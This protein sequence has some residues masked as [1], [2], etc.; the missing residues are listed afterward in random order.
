M[1]TATTQK[2]DGTGSEIRLPVVDVDVHPTVDHTDAAFQAHLS[3]RWRRYLERFGTGNIATES[4]IPPQRAMTH[5]LDAVD[6]SGRVASDPVFTRKQL[7]DEFDMSGALLSDAM[8][9]VYSRGGQNY[10]EALA[11]EL[12]SAYNDVHREVWFESDPRYYASINL[13]F[14]H[15]EKAAAEIARCREGE[16]GDR[17]AAALV[18]SRAE[19]PIGNPRYWPIFEACEHYGIPL[20]MHTSM[21]RRMTGCGPINFYFEWHTGF[22]QRNP[23]IVS[24]MVF[25]G[26]FDRFPGLNVVL[27]EQSWAWAVPYA[28]RL[29]STWQMLRDEV[30]DLER[31][32]S[33]YFAD[34]WYFA[35]QPMPEPEN[36]E[37]IDQVLDQF[38]GFFGP[39]HLLFASDYPHW[40]FDSPYDAM[41]MTLS[42]EQRGRILGG[43]ASKVLGI[44][45]LPNSGVRLQ[46]EAAAA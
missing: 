13:P 29:D 21:G 36:P 26:V 6:P 4:T 11:L 39:D 38:E 41:P 44:P 9:I 46:G 42:V 2:S 43:S 40:D 22:P 17:F 34:H 31:K 18:E 32:P 3:E 14:E 16:F 1:A 28:W 5:R 15:P 24:S 25:E 23:G 35:T 30:P 19:H 20:A 45:L 37:D 27:I 33:E 12:C 7:L 8:G 10:P